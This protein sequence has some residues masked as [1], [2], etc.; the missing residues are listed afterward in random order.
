M[1]TNL[2][3]ILRRQLNKLFKIRTFRLKFDSK[4]RNQ[5]HIMS[6][7]CLTQS[8]QAFYFPRVKN[9]QRQP[10]VMYIRFMTAGRKGR[11]GEELE[12]SHGQKLL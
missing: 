6:F 2:N 9:V 5:T 12:W 3:H 7:F 11:K 1:I 4:N 8:P 10:F